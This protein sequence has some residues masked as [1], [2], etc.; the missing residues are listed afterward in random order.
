M[1]AVVL[2]GLVL[3]ACGSSSSTS[4]TTTTT[5]GSKSGSAAG[6]VLGA[7]Y[8]TSIGFPKTVQAA[9]TTAVTQQKDC[10]SSVEAVYEDSVG[11]TGLIS[12]VLTCSSNAAA[13]AALAVARKHATIEPSVTVPKA[14]GP[15]AFATNSSAPEYLMIWQAGTKV[16]ITAIDVDVSSSSAGKAS[17]TPLTAAQGTTLSQAAVEQNSLYQ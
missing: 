17:E 11:K 9:K 1:T 16:A 3:A 5:S 7:S 2:A 4:S 15:T 14:L 12:D 13:V 10:L 6:L 8:A